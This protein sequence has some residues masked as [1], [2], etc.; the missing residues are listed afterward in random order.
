MCV[1]FLG[2][3]PLILSLFLGLGG[4]YAFTYKKGVVDPSFMQPWLEWCIYHRKRAKQV[5]ETWEKL[6]KSAQP[7][8]QVSFLYLSNDILQNSRRKG[9]EFVNEFWKVLPSA[10]KGYYGGGNENCREVVSRLEH[11]AP[12]A[13]GDESLNRLDEVTIWEDRKV[14]GSRGQNL[15]NEVLR[16]NQSLPVNNVKNANPIKVMKRDATFLR[17]KLA[18]GGLPERILTAM[19]LLH[20]EV[21][22]E[23][24]ALNKCHDAVSCV[25]E[26][27][28]VLNASSQLADQQQHYP[29]AST[30][31]AKSG[32]RGDRMYA[33]LP[34]C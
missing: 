11:V 12:C 2:M 13:S 18:V 22:S 5:V 17:I 1:L 31:P 33:A 14:F 20:D 25:R 8:Q 19:Q 23:E 29:N 30:A 15:K 24:A 9:S 6:F 21:A 10:L 16:K 27:D 32:V 7:Q 34:L 28:D 4:I 26:L 3:R